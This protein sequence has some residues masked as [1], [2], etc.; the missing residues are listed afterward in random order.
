MC[1]DCFGAPGCGGGRMNPPRGRLV[2]VLLLVVT[3]ILVSPRT[4]GRASAD[5]NN[6]FGCETTIENPHISEGPG[7]PGGVIAKGHFHCETT[8][9]LA[10]YDDYLRL[11][12]CDE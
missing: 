10:Y 9:T 1:S 7:S 3:G 6:P 8:T 2:W 5:P 4:E 12:R 11:Y